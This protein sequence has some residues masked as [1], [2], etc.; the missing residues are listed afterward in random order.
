[1]SELQSSLTAFAILFAL[2]ASFVLGGCIA[3]AGNREAA[4]KAN[5]AEFYIDENNSRQW[6]WKEVK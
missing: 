5:H 4:V 2:V 1:M 3:D 6:R